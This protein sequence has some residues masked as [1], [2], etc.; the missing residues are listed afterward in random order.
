MNNIYREELQAPILQLILQT[1]E[2]EF[3]KFESVKNEV[4]QFI[5]DNGIIDKL[6]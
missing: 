3:I 5:K 1:F 6:K 2:K 4:E